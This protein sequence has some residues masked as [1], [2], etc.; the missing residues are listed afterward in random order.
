MLFNGC[1]LYSSVSA[2]L[3]RE[4][5]PPALSAVYRSMRRNAVVYDG[6]EGLHIGVTTVSKL[7]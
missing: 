5:I 7:D 2:F 4:S 3:I 6:M 1:L